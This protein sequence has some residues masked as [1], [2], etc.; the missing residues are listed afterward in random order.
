MNNFTDKLNFILTFIIIIFFF[1]GF[2]RFI[3]QVNYPTGESN[4]FNLHFN[5]LSKLITE[6]TQNISS[7]NICKKIKNKIIFR[8]DLRISFEKFRI[9]LIN[10]INKVMGGNSLSTSFSLMLGSLIISSFFISILSVEKNLYKLIIKS[11]KN[12]ILLLSIFFLILAYYSIRPASELRFSF[13]EMFFISLSLYSS[14][15][16]KYLIFLL[17]II[18]STLNR[19][20]SIIIAS[21]WIIIN[22]IN[23]KANKIYFDKREIIVGFVYILISIIALIS[24]NFKIFSCGLNV[25]D[26]LTAGLE[27]NSNNSPSLLSNIQSLFSN[28]ILIIFL[29]YYL[30]VGSQKQMKLILIVMLYNIIFIFFTPMWH[31]ILRIMFAPIFVLYAYEFLNNNKNKQKLT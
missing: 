3:T 18:F 27:G 29:L 9:N 4:K 24:L 23:F 26:F 30:Y 8:H 22:G 13:F 28:Y 1:I 17:T 31:G 11:K 6:R 20:S 21:V 19:E 25:V 15:K 12:F 2:A 16:K 7:K 5:G 10:L 14:Y